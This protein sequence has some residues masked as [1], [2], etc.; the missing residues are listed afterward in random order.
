[1]YPIHL[2]KDLAKLA[3]GDYCYF[4]L[5]PNPRKIITPDQIQFHCL[6]CN[7]TDGLKLRLD[8]RTK[9]VWHREQMQHFTI[10]VLLRNVATRKFLLMKKRTFPQVI[11]NVAGHVTIDETP[12]QTLLRETAQET[13]FTLEKYKLLWEGLSEN[14]LCRRGAPHHYW[15]IFYSEFQGTPTPDLQ[16]VAYFKEYSWE[17]ILAEK[18]LNPAIKNIIAGFSTSLL[19]LP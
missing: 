5:A 16:E 14:D 17:E 11:D 13:G 10:G 1:M 3:D 8:N 12:E 2:K 4:C 19:E 18:M 9:T 6:Q 15:Y 7:K